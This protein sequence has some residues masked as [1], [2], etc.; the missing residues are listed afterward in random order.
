MLLKNK[1]TKHLYNSL[2]IL[3]SSGFWKIKEQK[4]RVQFTVTKKSFTV[5]LC[6]DLKAARV[7]GCLPRDG[8]F[9]FGEMCDIRTNKTAILTDRDCNPYLVPS[10]PARFPPAQSAI[11]CSR[12]GSLPTGCYSAAPPRSS[13]AAPPD[14]Y[15]TQTHC[16]ISH[17][18]PRGWGSCLGF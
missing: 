7:C 8:G 14:V 3:G 16:T 13:S 6:I 5:C 15:S 10:V 4:K 2:S 12:W 17:L 18:L 1:Q 9:A 11:Q